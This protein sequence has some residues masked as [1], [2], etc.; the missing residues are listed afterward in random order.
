[1]EPRHFSE[2]ETFALGKTQMT[3]RETKQDIYY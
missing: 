2:T 3:R 1:M